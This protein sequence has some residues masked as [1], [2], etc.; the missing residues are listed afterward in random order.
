MKS[1]LI[2]SLIIFSPCHGLRRMPSMIDL[3]PTPQEFDLNETHR[4]KRHTVQLPDD[5]LVTSL[6]YLN[7]ST[8]KTK[9]YAGHLPA[10][11][12]ASK[13]IFYWLFEPDFDTN[14]NNN[15]PDT[16]EVPLIIWLN[17]GPGCTSLVGLFIENGPLRFKPNRE[18]SGGNYQLESNPYSWHKAPAWV[19]YVDQPVGT[20]LSY[21]LNNKYCGNDFE[22]NTD[23]YYFLTEFFLLYRSTFLSLNDYGSYTVKRPLYF[24]GESHAGHYIPSMMDFILQQNDKHNST[25]VMPLSGAAI[26]NGWIN[27]Y[28]QYAGAEAAE[29]MGLID[30][31]QRRRLDQSEIT[32]QTRL[33][34][35][36]FDGSGCL[37]LI[38][39][40]VGNS[41]GRGVSQVNSYDVNLK[42][43][44]RYPPGVELIESYFGSRMPINP[45]M[46]DI[47]IDSVLESLHATGY[48]SIGSYSVCADNPYIALAHQDGLGV[49]VELGNVLDHPTRPRIL[50]Y[51][52]MRD[53]VCNHVGSER[54]LDNLKWHG[55]DNWIVAERYTFNAGDQ[56]RPDGFIKEYDNLIFLK[57]PQAGHMV[58]MDQPTQT[59]AMIRR[60]VYK[61]DFQ[62]L[63]QD[64]DSTN[65][66][67]ASLVQ[68]QVC[69]PCENQSKPSESVTGATTEISKQ[70]VLVGF[71]VGL[72]LSFLLYLMWRR[73]DTM[74]SARHSS[75]P[76]S[77]SELE[78]GTNK[79]RPM[80]Y[81]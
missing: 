75:Y 1:A 36:I 76:V 12:D 59:L 18:A 16:D 34:A 32:C 29:L 4:R 70:S 56:L 31:A 26:G 51:N 11:S 57:I 79:P 27:P 13:Q 22:I 53:L 74:Y 39:E 8:F 45:S 38:D 60:L 3:F 10:S 62:S 21:T 77:Q 17:G 41:Y 65:P 35:K 9:Q 48:S 54:T 67:N 46:H 30:A 52:G 64:L 73:T 7:L 49:A 61:H 78:E 55:Q 44:G 47:T 80:I 68:C 40:I 66:W 50:I 37:P 25:V 33:D 81:T 5:H 24:S 14:S 19:L 69:S 6:P 42:S 63:S 71:S 2:S 72:V 23:F 43:N 28:Y 58:P 20:G 15:R